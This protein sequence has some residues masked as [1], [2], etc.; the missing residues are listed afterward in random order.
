MKRTL[1]KLFLFLLVAA[2]VAVVVYAYFGDL[3]P[4]QT[5]I[6]EPVRLN[7]E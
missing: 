7:V 1:L 2:A 3:S 6:R 4:K 5:E